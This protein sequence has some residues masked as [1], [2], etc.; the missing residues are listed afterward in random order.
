[1]EKTSDAYIEPEMEEKQERMER[2]A[3]PFNFVVSP[4]ALRP[5]FDHRVLF[6]RTGLGASESD[7]D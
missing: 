5:H 7:S 2:K 1:M 4:P 6:I 3:E